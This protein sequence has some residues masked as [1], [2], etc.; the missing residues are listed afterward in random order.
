MAQLRTRTL[1]GAGGARPGVR[2][3]EQGLAQIVLTAPGVLRPRLR[4][5]WRPAA[6]LMVVPYI[7]LVLAYA[8]FRAPHVN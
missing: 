8:P 3:A 2:A 7:E 1:A 5:N 4:S 6:V